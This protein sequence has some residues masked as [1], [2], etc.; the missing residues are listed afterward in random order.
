MQQTFSKLNNEILGLLF[1]KGGLLAA[2]TGK[3][4]KIKEWLQSHQPL[5]APLFLCGGREGIRSCAKAARCLSAL[6]C[7]PGNI[8][9]TAST[10]WIDVNPLTF[11]LHS[12][13]FPNTLVDTALAPGA[14]LNQR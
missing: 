11:P 6:F 12:Q 1:L 4:G 8:T 14:Q 2:Q 5:T 3:N 9:S 13:Y 10:P 7:S